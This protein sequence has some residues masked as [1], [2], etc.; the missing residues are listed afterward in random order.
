MHTKLRQKPPFYL[1]TTGKTLENPG[2]S[3]NF[4]FVLENPGRKPKLEKCPENLLEF[5]I[6]HQL[7]IQVGSQL[8]SCSLLKLIFFYYF[9]CD[10]KNSKNLYIN[11]CR[12]FF[13]LSL[14]CF[15]KL[16]CFL[17]MLFYI[18]EC[19]SLGCQHSDR[20]IT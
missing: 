18:L 13:S 6:F 4:I 17:Y 16:F 7:E 15:L 8:A 14:F 1:S 5:L 12:A 10:M 19:V 11:I 3:W 20:R 2:M 9:L